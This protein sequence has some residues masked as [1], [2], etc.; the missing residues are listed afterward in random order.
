VKKLTLQNRKNSLYFNQK[1]RLWHK[2]WQL[3]REVLGKF[4]G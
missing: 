2:I 3:V 4:R 1:A